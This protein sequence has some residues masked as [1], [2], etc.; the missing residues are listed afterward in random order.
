MKN[1]FQ[2]LEYGIDSGSA[3]SCED[4]SDADVH[5]RDQS[6][7]L[8]ALISPIPIPMTRYRIE[9]PPNVCSMEDRPGN[10][11]EVQENDTSEEAA[12]RKSRRPLLAVTRKV[13]SA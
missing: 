11:P 7:R 6:H 5:R 3:L 9:P 10:T 13:E 4:A 8:R 1:W 12:V 2:R